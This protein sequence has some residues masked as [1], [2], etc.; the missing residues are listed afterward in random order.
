MRSRKNKMEK[1]LLKNLEQL[2]RTF[3]EKIISWG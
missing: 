2:N 1:L 3:N